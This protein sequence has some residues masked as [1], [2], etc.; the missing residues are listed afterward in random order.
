VSIQNIPVDPAPPGDNQVLTYVA[1]AGKYSPKSGGG[2]SGG[3]QA[4]K[5]ATD[6]SWTQSPSADLSAAGSKTVTLVACPIGVLGTEPYYYV[7]V[8]G[9]GTPE[10]VAVTGGTCA[11]NGQPGTLQFT[12]LNA[13]PAGY[14]IGSASSGLQE[15]LIAARITPGNPTGPQQAGK[16]VVPPGELALYARVSVRSSDITVDF[17]GA[18]LN[19]YMQDTCIFVGDPLNANAFLDIT[20]VSPRGRPMIVNGQNPFIRAVAAKEVVDEAGFKSGL[21]KI[22]DG[23]VDVLNA[24]AWAP[25]AQ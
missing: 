24:S 23:V 20:L 4:I 22:V 14:T 18:I 3:M 5:Y 7:Y 19:C 21:S 13:H 16:V 17:S 9:T 2:V 25:K 1:S 10:A 6:F 15:A 12:T 8:A 11:G